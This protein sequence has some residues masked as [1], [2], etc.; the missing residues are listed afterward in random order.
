MYNADETGL[1]FKSLPNKTLAAKDDKCIGGKL[2]KERL[3]VLLCA[4]ASG[5]KLK[6]LVIG[7]SKQPRSFG[8]LK[9]SQLPVNWK[10]SKKAWMTGDLFEQWLHELNNKMI[11]ERRKILLFIDNATVHCTATLS[12]VNIKFF[13]P[14]TTSILQPLDQGIIK[15][16]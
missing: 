2:S 4:N 15:N 9:H 5:E 16:F 11:F 12:N 7:K 10:W 8:R 13:P 6:P 14:N 1:F 3:T